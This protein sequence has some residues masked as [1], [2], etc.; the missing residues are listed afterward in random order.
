MALV[1]CQ[2]LPVVFLLS[3]CSILCNQKVI[4][5]PLHQTHG[6]SWKLLLFIV[7]HCS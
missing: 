5:M 7:P 2:V 4:K 6:G 1:P 3:Y